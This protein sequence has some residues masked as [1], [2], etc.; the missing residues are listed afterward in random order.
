MLVNKIFHNQI[1]R[2][3]EVYIDDMLVKSKKMED[4]IKDLDEAFKI[5]K[6]YNIKLNPSKCAFGV[7]SGKF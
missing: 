5:L 2:N 7:S 6:Q 4:H 1:E 3:M